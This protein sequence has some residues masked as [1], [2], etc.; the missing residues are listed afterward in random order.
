MRLR[1]WLRL[2]CRYYAG[3]VAVIAGVDLLPD[4]VDDP[5]SFR[6]MGG[7]LLSSR[8]LDVDTDC[9]GAAGFGATGVG[10]VGGIGS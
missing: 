1:L 7:D 4:E 6:L 10:A 5:G 9:D 2:R 3:V 8:R